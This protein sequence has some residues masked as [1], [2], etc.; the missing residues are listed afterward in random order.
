MAEL[1]LPL[2]Q[3]QVAVAIGV[4]G[5]WI[6]WQ[7]GMRRMVGFYD[8]PTATR[9]LIYGI[10]TGAIYQSIA[11]M[12]VMDPMWQGK[13]APL[14]LLFLVPLFISTLTMFLLTREG[15]RRLNGQPTAGWAFGLGLGS[16]LVVLLMY[17][18]F[19]AD[20]SLGFWLTGFNPATLLL[21]AA[22]SAVV[23]WT[24]AIIASWQGW[25]ALE[26]RRFKPTFKATLLHA[27]LLVL[28][29]FGIV[30]PIALFALPAFI[31]WGQAQADAVWLPAGLSPRMKQEWKRL[32]RTGVSTGVRAVA[33]EEE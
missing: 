21:G 23:P 14:L 24:M 2:W 10:V 1:G 13:P 16:M 22:L 9:L 12:L 17:R 5:V 30:Y 28:L 26:L 29:A 33:T 20:P 4:I 18:I 32:Q 8:L 27:M 6:G 11:S 15:V 19:T 3:L 7:G 25:H 31:L